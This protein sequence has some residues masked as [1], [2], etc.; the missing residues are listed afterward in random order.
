MGVMVRGDLS[1]DG[2]SN[3]GSCNDSSR[4]ASVVFL[5]YDDGSRGNDNWVDN[6]GRGHNDGG[7]SVADS[8]HLD[9]SSVVEHEVLEVDLLDREISSDVKGVDVIGISSVGE[10]SDVVTIDVEGKVVMVVLDLHVEVHSNVE[11]I[12]ETNLGVPYSE[13]EVVQNDDSLV[14]SNGEMED[15]ASRS[16]EFNDE[17]VSGSHEGSSLN[18]DLSIV[19]HSS[20][21]WSSQGNHGMLD[22]VNHGWLL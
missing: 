4:M 16:E 7:G 10:V 11:G 14:E 5:H 19:L 22:D 3:N 2:T 8:A 21:H 1:S 18:L 13:V 9:T 17:G 20:D 12:G 15:G 6:G